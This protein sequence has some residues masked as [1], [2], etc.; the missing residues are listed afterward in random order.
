MTPKQKDQ[1]W[2]ESQ[3]ADNAKAAKRHRDAIT[4]QYVDE[5]HV[6]ANPDTTVT[7][8]RK[9]GRMAELIAAINANTEV[10]RGILAVL[11]ED[12]AAAAEEEEPE[13]PASPYL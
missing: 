11:I 12:A 3:R 13:E 5:D 9:P 1:A 10:Q 4:G 8:T 6:K 7:E 2:V